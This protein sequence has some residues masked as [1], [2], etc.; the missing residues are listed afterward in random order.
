MIGGMERL[1]AVMK[2]RLLHQ[3][4]YKTLGKSSRDQVIALPIVA[5]VPAKAGLIA[6][7]L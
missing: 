7:K 4:K 1:V 6:P 3:M 2:T 5:A